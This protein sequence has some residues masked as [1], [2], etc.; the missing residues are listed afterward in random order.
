MSQ[1]RRGADY[2][3]LQDAQVGRVRR[4]D[5]ERSLLIT[6]Y[7]P[8]G[9]ALKG[10]PT[11]GD[12]KFPFFKDVPDV[13]GPYALR[14]T[15][16][17]FGIAPGNLNVLPQ[18]SDPYADEGDQG[19]YERSPLVDVRGIRQ[20]VLVADYILGDE[21]TGEL[22]IIPQARLQPVRVT[23]NELED[24]QFRTIGVVDPTI[25]VPGVVQSYG[26][27]RCYPTE[28]RIAPNYD[29]A[30]PLIPVPIAPNTS[31]PV[32]LAFDVGIYDEFRFMWGEL[33]GATRP[34]LRARYFL[35]R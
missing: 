26:M 32:T 14:E 13:A 30:N 5:G 4:G 1:K 17:G 31:V 25:V 2:R 19:A 8:G 9:D 18:V 33:T 23:G 28:L 10:R 7:A 20:L 22:S 12:Q 24:E 34:T 29:P 15:E 35:M 11:P 3:R 27:R 16:N 6:G 21:G